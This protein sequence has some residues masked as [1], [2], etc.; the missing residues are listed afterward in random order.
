MNLNEIASKSELN[1][2]GAEQGPLAGCW[3][4]GNEQNLSTTRGKIL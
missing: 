1:S 4:Q 2:C 3:V